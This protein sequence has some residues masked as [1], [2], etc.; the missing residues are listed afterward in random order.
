MNKPFKS[1]KFSVLLVLGFLGILSNATTQNTRSSISFTEAP[2]FHGVASGDP[3]PEQVMIWTR[4]SPFSGST[5]E[6]EVNWQIAT[7]TAFQNIV[8]FGSIKTTDSSDFTVKIDVCGLQPNT[9]YYYVFRALGKNS[10]IGRTKTAPIGNNTSARYAVAS[11][12]NYEHGF[13]NAYESMANRNDL[14][15]VIHLGDYYYEYESGGFSSSVVIDDWERTVLPTHE[16]INL[17]DYR[18]RHSHYKLD[19]QLQMVH[20]LYP[21][22][23]TWDDHETANDSYKDGAENH[24]L[25][26]EGPWL[27]RKISSAQAYEEWMPIRTDTAD[28]SKIW[29]KLR[30]GNLLDLIIIDSRLWGRDEQNMSQSDNPNHKLLGEDQFTWLETQLADTTTQWK[31]IC[32]QMMMAPLEILGLAVNAD[33]W[34]GYNNERERLINYLAANNIKNTVVLTGDIHTSWVNNIPTS[35]GNVATEFVVTSVT[36]P[37]LDVIETA[38]GQLPQWLLNS[39]GGSV[40]GVIKFMN[41][42]IEYVNIED[43]GYMVFTVDETKAQGDYINVERED[44]I[45]SD[46]FSASWYTA[47]NNSVMQEANSH[48][49]IN[50]GAIKPPLSPRQNISFALLEDTVF[51]SMNENS[52]LN[53]CLVDVSNL[54]PNVNTAIIQNATSGNVIINEF[55]YEFQTITNYYGN[56]NFSVEICSNTIPVQCDTVV[57]IVEI[58]GINDIQ[59]YNYTFSNDSILEDCI[60]FNDLTTTIDSISTIGGLSGNFII[61]T[62]NCF[63]FQAD[64]TFCGLD[65]ITIIACD[66]NGICDTVILNFEIN[67]KVSIQTVNLYGEDGDLLSN[68]LAYD[69]LQGNIVTTTFVANASNGGALIYNDTCL[70]YQSDLLFD[71][72]DTIILV[73]CD[74]YVPAKCDTIV[75]YIHITHP[76]DTTIV[77]T[78]IEPNPIQELENNEFAILGIFPNPFDVEIVIQYYQFSGENIS[79]KL[80]DLS[81]KLLFKENLND[82]MVGLKYTRLKTA[83]LPKANYILEINNGKFSYIKKMIK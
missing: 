59:T 14:D 8:N 56:Q 23:T 66:N 28:N 18:A 55:C 35:S 6:L 69:E 40:P 4:V 78:I 47:N 32:N 33:Q 58:I 68:C 54:C 3:L 43:H 2:F 7:D 45:F 21:F 62:N 9:Y 25:V 53:N 73:A 37:G 46:E 52:V 82:N 67:G 15:A 19:N 74:D 36:S 79:L 61:D 10:I 63:T 42:H 20:Q 70:S 22:I 41:S 5:T 75:Y 71:G 30:Y 24:D 39:L 72:I 26:T 65:E 76:I 83:L 44:T 50:T 16:A 38:L 60:Q 34:D 57:V 11:C 64:S 77:D 49:S 51:V 12:S 1:M 13:F 29:R 17:E 81:G 48:L 27:N 31:I 80:Y